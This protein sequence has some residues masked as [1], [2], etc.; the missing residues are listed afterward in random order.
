MEWPEFT[1]INFAGDRRSARKGPKCTFPSLFFFFQRAARRGLEGIFVFHPYAKHGRRFLPSRYWRCTAKVLRLDSRFSGLLSG[2][3]APC[4]I[5][6][7]SFTFL[8][9]GSGPREFYLFKVRKW[10][11][12]LCHVR[13]TVVLFDWIAPGCL[14]VKV[15][16]VKDTINAFH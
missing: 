5:A 16:N 3:Q 4:N 15:S 2:V 13:E 9:C 12:Q 7:G 14:S 1:R 8:E 6:F 10:S 11:R